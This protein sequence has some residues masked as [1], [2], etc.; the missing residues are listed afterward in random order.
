Q[1]ELDLSCS[2]VCKAWQKAGMQP[3]TPGKEQVVGMGHAEPGRREPRK[4]LNST[5][6]HP[7]GVGLGRISLWAGRGNADAQQ[8][9]YAMAVQAF[10]SAIR[11][12]PWEHRL[13]GNRSYCYEKLGCFQEALGDAVAALALQP[14]WA[15]GL[16]RKGKALRGLQRYAE[17]ARTFEELLRGDGASAEARAQLEECRALLRVSPPTDPQPTP[18]PGPAL[19]PLLP[20]QRSPWQW[21][22][23]SCRDTD[24][25]GFE[26]VGSPR[27]QECGQGRV[28]ASGPQ[29]LLPSHPARD[30]FPLWV[31][32]VTTNI[33]EKVLRDAFSQF[34]EIRSIR[35]LPKRH[36]AFINFA[37]KEAAEAAYAAMQAAEL[38]GSRLA[39]QLKH[40]SHAT[41]APLR[42]P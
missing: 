21:V 8:G 38:G 19:T 41:P 24:T 29:T 25:S 40:P 28:A 1:E 10:S 30:C 23:R 22:R 17:A 9:R 18:A 33:S 35:T 14:A 11:L 6:S 2:F 4:G 26:T 16:F 39:L 3:P 20:Q 5:P 42:P 36:C 12:N 13:L 27:S 37:H 31:G 7:G 32:T 15:K 34:G